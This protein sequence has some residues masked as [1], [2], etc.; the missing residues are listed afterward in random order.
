[1]A[2]AACACRSI[3]SPVVRIGRHFAHTRPCTSRDQGS[4][5]RP[6]ERRS[7]PIPETTDQ[8]DGQLSKSCQSF[9]R[10]IFRFV[11]SA[12]RSPA[13][14][15]A[16]DDTE[17]GCAVAVRCLAR[18][19]S[20]SSSRRRPGPITTEDD[21]C[22]TLGPRLSSPTQSCGY[23]SRPSPGRH[24]EGAVC[25]HILRCHRPARPG[26]SVCR[27][28]SIQAQASLEYWIPACAHSRV[29]TPRRLTS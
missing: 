14:A 12:T 19:A 15:C 20:S 3:M 28:L 11:R 13:C 24:V 29:M 4:P 1:M 9:T 5:L 7:R 23:G 8:F 27:G 21:C 26:D 22:A 16:G 25:W 17:E 18:E 6:T 2:I 10:R